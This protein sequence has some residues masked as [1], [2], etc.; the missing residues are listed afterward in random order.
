METAVADGTL[1]ARDADASV[2]SVGA[3]ECTAAAALGFFDVREVNWRKGREG[4]SK[5]FD[6]WSKRSS[7]LQ[8]RPTVDWRRNARKADAN[9]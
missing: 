7:Y 5:W 8:S 6:G 2:G 3:E 4:L 1:R 9:L